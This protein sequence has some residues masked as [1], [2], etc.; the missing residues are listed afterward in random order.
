[1]E[2]GCERVVG[3]VACRLGHERLLLG[4]LL[5][6]E[7]V[8]L[9]LSR[10]LFSLQLLLLRLV[11]HLEVGLL[12]GLLLSLLLLEELL[13]IEGLGE[14]VGNRWP[15]SVRVQDRRLSEGSR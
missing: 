4:E 3:A 1:M 11:L 7:E 15:W 12:L 10:R 5:L 2:A 14:E 6:L 9:L 8:L 13:L